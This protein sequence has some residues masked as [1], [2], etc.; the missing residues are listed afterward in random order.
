MT[1][2]RVS[3]LG[4]GVSAH[5]ALNGYVANSPFADSGGTAEVVLLLL[6]DDQLRAVDATELPRYRRALLPAAEFPM[7]LPSGERLDAAYL[8]VNATGV[9]AA[10]DG[11]PRVPGAQVELLAELLHRSP[12]LREL[13]DSPHDWVTKARADADLRA[14]VKRIFHE[15]GWVLAHDRAL[16]LAT[17]RDHP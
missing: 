11:R 5:V 2:L 13:F 1:P 12:R 16:P 14:V 17:G 8:Y 9:L 15:S 6:D 4:I 3:G 10:A 7:V